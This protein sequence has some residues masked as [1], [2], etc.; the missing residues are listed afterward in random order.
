[1]RRTA[2]R[3]GIRMLKFVDV[4]GRWETSELSQ[5]EAAELLGMG[6]RSFRR[7]CRRYEEDGEA[8]LLDRRI[9]KASGKRVPVDRCEEV[10]ALYRSRYQGFTARHFH[11]HLVRE[12]RFAW[13]YSWTKTFLQSRHLLAKAPRRGVHR[14]KRPRRPLPGMMLHQDAS[15][16]AWLAGG[17]PLDL[18]VTM[19]DATS[20]VYSAFLVEEEGT[21][22]TFRALL[23][24]FGC[25][26]LPLSLYTDRGSHYFHTAEAGGKVDRGQPTQA[27]RALA[28][29]GVEH[30]AAYSPQARGRS[31]RLFQTLQ[32]RVPKEL[33]LAGIT[34]LEAANAW[35]RDTYI[36][37]HNARFA[38]KAEQEGSAFVAVPA[39]DLTEILCVQEERVVGNDNCVAFLNRRLQIPASPLRAHFVKATVKVHQYSDGGL[40]VFHGRMCLGRYDSTGVPIGAPGSA[41]GETKPLV[42]TCG[43]AGAVLGAVKDAA[44]RDAVASPRARP[45]LTAPVRVARSHA[46]SAPGNGPDSL[47]RKCPSETPLLRR[48]K[49]ERAATSC[50]T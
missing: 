40:A 6:E 27:G 32:D 47:T 7:W 31:E 42:P 13:S 35:L 29:L 30:I 28:H 8:G 25:H 21:A 4:F 49:R 37:A 36:P 11:E 26:G 2:A 18:V 12:H 43:E 9:G 34:T 46:R 22:S 33:A 14:R 48:T 3:Q 15:R 24:V 41:G 39:L 23:E 20:E 50:V 5:L 1:M 19:D 38:M 45:S 10:E 16:H 17:P 44:R